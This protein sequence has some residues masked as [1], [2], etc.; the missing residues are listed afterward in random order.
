[1]KQR[2]EFLKGNGYPQR[3]QDLIQV[4]ATSDDEVDPTGL[5][6]NR[7]QVYWIKKRPERSAEAE[8]FLR[9]LDEAQEGQAIVDGKRLGQ[10]CL[11][12][13]SEEN[14]KVTEFP[15]VATGMP[16]DY[17]SPTFFNSQ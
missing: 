14:K 11:R 17:F 9:L 8:I 6:I 16:I 5:K 2:L 3:Y 7:H 1:M 13:V 4:K 12:M 15:A 10:E